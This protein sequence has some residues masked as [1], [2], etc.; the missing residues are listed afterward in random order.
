[1]NIPNLSNIASNIASK[2]DPA[3]DVI[4]AEQLIDSL[5]KYTGLEPP[6]AA[7][8]TILHAIC[9]QSNITNNPNLYNVMVEYVYQNLIP[10][11][12]DI[13]LAQNNERIVS[14]LFGLD[15]NVKEEETDEQEDE[16][17]V[18]P[19]QT[20]VPEP[21]SQIT[22]DSQSTIVSTPQK[23]AA[24]GAGDET[25][26]IYNKTPS[27]Y[28]DAAGKWLK[29][30]RGGDGDSTDLDKMPE[31]IKQAIEATTV[32]IVDSI[33]DDTYTDKMRASYKNGEDMMIYKYLVKK[34]L[35]RLTSAVQGKH[36]RKR[37]REIGLKHMAPIIE[38][39]RRRLHH[40]ANEF[41]I[42]NL[43]NMK[44]VINDWIITDQSTD[45]IK[46]KN[47]V[48]DNYLSTLF[49]LYYVEYN[50]RSEADISFDFIETI[51]GYVLGITD[52][53]SVKYMADKIPIMTNV[54]NIKG[55][56]STEDA[57]VSFKN[58]FVSSPQG[59]AENSLLTSMKNWGAKVKT[60]VSGK[61]KPSSVA[62]DTAAS[63]PPTGGSKKNRRTK[64][65]QREK[66]NKTRRVK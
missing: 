44:R 16:V 34:N 30:I 35:D 18:A 1:M 47:D 56:A 59:T 54:N 17:S 19:E 58:I 43:N 62:P 4:S 41:L 66:R 8:E 36:H 45:T 51:K 20:L 9:S 23:V 29:T 3:D 10:S 12:T 42:A 55:K 38:D 24:A 21:V 5:T 63:T 53:Q 14:L 33:K 22:P 49:H 6:R 31:L 2:M 52:K 26:I 7:V 50:Y 40:M 37:N 57:L 39:S 64:R 25:N 61:T 11:Y 15:D 60:F 13:I 46:S 32:L 27:R 48:I 65:H 28:A